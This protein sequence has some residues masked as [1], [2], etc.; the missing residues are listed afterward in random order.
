[1][2]CRPG[3]TGDTG[4]AVPTRLTTI[5]RHD[6]ARREVH[7]RGPAVSADEPADTAPEPFLRLVLAMKDWTAMPDE[8]AAQASAALG[9]RQARPQRP[10]PPEGA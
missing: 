9:G 4:M 5:P 10:G 2:D 3:P 8:P 7:I 1:M 6:P